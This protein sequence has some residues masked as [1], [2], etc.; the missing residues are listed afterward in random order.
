MTAFFGVGDG[1]TRNILQQT[2]RLWSGIDGVLGS[3]ALLV[4]RDCIEMNIN[5]N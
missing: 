1:D 5:V 2:D 3:K 4:G